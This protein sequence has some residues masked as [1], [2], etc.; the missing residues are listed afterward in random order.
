M[1]LRG[2]LWQHRKRLISCRQRAE[3]AKDL[4]YKDNKAPAKVTFSTLEK[5]LSQGQGP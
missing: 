2:S 5:L 3:Q 4:N 1:K